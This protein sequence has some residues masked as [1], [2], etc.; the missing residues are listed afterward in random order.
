MGANALDGK[1][2][3]RLRT[4]GILAICIGAVLSGCGGGGGGYGNNNN[5]PPASTTPPPTTNP[6]TT[7][8]LFQ[9]VQDQ[10]LTPNCTGCH[11]GPNAPQGLRLD[12]GNS[13]ALLVNVPSN[14]MAGTLRVK[15]GDP[16]NSW[17]VKKIDGTATVGGRMPLGRAALPQTSIDL[18]RSWISAG[19]TMNSGVDDGRFSIQS[20]IPAAGE[21]SV[22]AVK[23]FQI[24]FNSEIDASLV[25]SVGV[26]IEASG[27]DGSFAEGNE[28]IL[29][30]ADV[31]VSP[32]NARVLLVHP[33]A[34]LIGDDYRLVI[35]QSDGISLADN[36]ARA[37]DGDGDGKAG[38]A[39]TL[40][41]HGALSA[42]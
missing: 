35:D 40:T 19:A 10:V 22:A 37:L 14:Q 7:T 27:G 9:Q 32:A 12:A 39:F 16:D 17:L 5:N 8:S 4:H 25:Q 34:P 1:A 42:K 20:T 33:A 31:S 23:E 6:P 2:V 30:L 24:I 13:Y 18:V 41:F 11:V 29:S 15:P 36:A 26:S 28:S 3:S 38:G 21:M